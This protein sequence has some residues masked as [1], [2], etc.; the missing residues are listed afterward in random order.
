MLSTVISEMTHSFHSWSPLSPSSVDIVYN[1]NSSI[2][3]E[4][5]GG[6]SL[7]ARAYGKCII[8]PQKIVGPC[9]IV[10]GNI[11]RKTVNNSSDSCGKWLSSK[12]ADVFET[13][14]S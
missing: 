3:H 2:E 5:L 12:A 8:A 4:L 6:A 14:K 10:N 7:P 13:N 9:Q 1:F 11:W